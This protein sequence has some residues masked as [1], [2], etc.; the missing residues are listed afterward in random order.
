MPVSSLE[1]EVLSNSC[2]DGKANSR[3]VG[4]LSTLVRSVNP[5]R[6]EAFLIALLNHRVGN[7]KAANFFLRRFHEFCRGGFPLTVREGLEAAWRLP[8]T[9]EREIGVLSA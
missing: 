9:L 5:K 4:G 6:A 2:Q 1:F 3:K 8:T 7:T